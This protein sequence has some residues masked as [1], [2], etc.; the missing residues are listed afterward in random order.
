M[1]Y[2]T[3]S[4]TSLAAD[5]PLIGRVQREIRDNEGHLLQIAEMETEQAEDVTTPILNTHNINDG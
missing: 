4:L 5:I 1:K 3:L 2:I